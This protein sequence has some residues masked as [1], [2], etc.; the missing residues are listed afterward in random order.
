MQVDADPLKV[1]EAFYLEIN[2]CMMIEANEGLEEEITTETFECLMVETTE[3]PD[4]AKELE[5]VYT[6]AGESLED[7]QEK[8]K[9]Y[10]SEAALCP[11]CNAVFKKKAAEKYEGKKVVPRFVF[12][13]KGNPRRNTEH[14][15]ATP[16]ARPRTF[17]P[18]S[19]TPPEKWVEEVSRKGR[20][21]PKW[22][23]IEMGKTAEPS[24]NNV[25]A[26]GYMISPNYKE[27]NPITRT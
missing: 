4:N 2:D 7:F 21:R 25:E 19:D 18:P 15:K 13:S 23:V 11:S 24:D 20:K 16:S 17:V 10:G 12:D 8:C 6:Q 27:K 22:K 14:Q 26:K 3:G 1:E 5:A 9:V